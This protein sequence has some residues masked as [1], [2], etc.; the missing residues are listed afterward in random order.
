LGLDLKTRERPGPIAGAFGSNE[1]I[2]ALAH[3]GYSTRL[4]TQRPPWR[5][6]RHRANRACGQA[7]RPPHSTHQTRTTELQTIAVLP[8]IAARA[9]RRQP[10]HPAPQR[11]L[12]RPSWLS[13]RATSSPT[14]L[15]RAKENEARIL[16]FVALSHA[17]C[18]LD[19]HD[20]PQLRV[21]HFPAVRSQIPCIKFALLGRPSEEC[22]ETLGFGAGVGGFRSPAAKKVP[23]RIN[24][25]R[26]YQGISRR[27]R[28]AR[29]CHHRHFH[30]S[31][32]SVVT[33]VAKTRKRSIAAGYQLG[34]KCTKSLSVVGARASSLTPFRSAAAKPLSEAHGPF[35]L[36]HAISPLVARVWRLSA[37]SRRLRRRACRAACHADDKRDPVRLRSE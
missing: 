9:S 4:A 13:R 25:C 14:R 10:M 24:V 33:S 28:S 16:S 29:D 23:A 17:K 27:D 22:G 12:T 15:R 6:R 26:E 3:P 31:F 2:A 11:R 30:D 35:A 20:A 19:A 18:D 32:Q 36:P 37:S 34:T 1:A 5:P 21:T 7:S 8:E